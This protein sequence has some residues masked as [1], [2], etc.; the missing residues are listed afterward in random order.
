[1]DVASFPDPRRL[2]STSKEVLVPSRGDIARPSAPGASDHQPTGSRKL[3]TILVATDGSPSS[4][5]AIRLAVELASEHRSEVLF[6]HVVPTLDVA[7]AA[8]SDEVGAALPPER[9]EQDHAVLEEASAFASG[10]GVVASTALLDGS[11]A[12]AI[13]AYAE[14]CDVNLIV[15]GS[16]A[17]GAVASALLGSVSLGVLR[18]STRPVLIVDG[19]TSVSYCGNGSCPDVRIFRRS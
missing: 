18:A 4:T 9:T 17:R 10:H 3:H 13:V 5:H 15:V 14:S 7:P 6:V 19:E 16:R 2:A 11:P 8:G 12:A 1:M